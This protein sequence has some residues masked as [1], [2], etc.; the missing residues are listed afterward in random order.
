MKVKRTEHV[1]A[2]AVA[3]FEQVLERLYPGIPF[4]VQEV[5]P[6]YN[7]I[8]RE[9]SEHKQQIY[10]YGV[11]FGISAMI[12]VLE[13]LVARRTVTREETLL[14][15]FYCL[16]DQFPKEEAN[17]EN[18]YNLES[19]LL[20]SM[21]VLESGTNAD[22]QS[23]FADCGSAFVETAAESLLMFKTS[24]VDADILRSYK[25]ERKGCEA[26]LASPP[27]WL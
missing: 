2:K 5:T 22:L 19:S 12:T 9:V 6:G 14:G 16:Q 27:L 26:C 25:G 1:P 24:Y 20:Q 8:N 11:T 4:T 10:K 17:N 7:E 18:K 13:S 3:M 15:S 23:D 21:L